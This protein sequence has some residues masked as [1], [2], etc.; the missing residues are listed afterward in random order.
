MVKA[1]SETLALFYSS[2]EQKMNQRKRTRIRI[3]RAAMTVGCDQNFIHFLFGQHLWKRADD[4]M[5]H[6]L[7]SRINDQDS[8]LR[9]PPVKRFDGSNAARQC[10]WTAGD[11]TLFF[12][13]FKESIQIISRNR[14]DGFIGRKEFGQQAHI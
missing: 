5:L 14:A 3:F 4:R 11:I 1:D 8:V 13:P 2:N 12:H 7:F 10:L 6:H 9:Q